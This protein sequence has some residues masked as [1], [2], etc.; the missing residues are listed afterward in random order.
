[1]KKVFLLIVLSCLFISCKNHVSSN[2]ENNQEEELLPNQVKIINYCEGLR[3]NYAYIIFCETDLEGERK[4]FTL[5]NSTLNYGE[6]KIFDILEIPEG[7]IPAWFGCEIE[8]LTTGQT[9]SKE[10]LD[11]KSVFYEYLKNKKF[12]LN[13]SKK[14]ITLTSTKQ[15]VFYATDF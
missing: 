14:F 7:H 9:Y 2:Q 8:N 12:R 4:I 6:S 1:M 10:T 3:I 5:P 11:F 13:N 15:L